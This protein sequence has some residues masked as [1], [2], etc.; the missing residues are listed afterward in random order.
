MDDDQVRTLIDR[1]P[2]LVEKYRE[3]RELLNRHRSGWIPF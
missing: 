2:D 3:Y 1:I